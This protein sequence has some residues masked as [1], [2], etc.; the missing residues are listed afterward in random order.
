M[1]TTNTKLQN[2]AEPFIT[3]CESFRRKLKDN[4][5]H[6]QSHATLQI[7]TEVESAVST[8]DRKSVV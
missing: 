3:L 7:E 6:K 8:T 4:L 2:N 5:I 1:Q